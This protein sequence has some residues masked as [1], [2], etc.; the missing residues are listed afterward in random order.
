MLPV[1]VGEHSTE[2]ARRDVSRFSL[3]YG[4]LQPVAAIADALAIMMV[5]GCA[6]LIYH[7]LAGS[8]KKLLDVNFLSVALMTA[9]LFITLSYLT[10]GYEPKTRA[11]RRASI[12]SALKIWALT[13]AFMVLCAFLSKVSAQYSRATMI[14]H[15]AGGAV[16]IT[17]I[18]MLWPHL[19]R[20]AMENNLV[21]TT[22]VLVVRIGDDPDASKA[23]DLVR[24]RELRNSGLRPVGSQVMSLGLSDGRMEQLIAFVDERFRLGQLNEVILLAGHDALSHLDEVVERLRVVPVPVRFVLDPVTHKVLTRP[25]KKVG[26]LI[27]AEYQ[28]APLSITERFFKR[29][30][31]IAVSLTGMMLLSPLLLIAALAVKLDSPGPVFFKQARRGFGGK[32]FLI[33]KLRSMAVQED[34]AAVVQA[35]RDDARVTRVG[36]LL[37]RTSIDELPQLWNVFAG[38]MSIVGPRPHAVAHDDYYSQLIEDYAF[39][40]HAKPG[41][42]GWAQVKGLRGETPHVENMKAR[43]EK[44]IW[45]IDNWSIWLDIM[46][47]LRTGLVVLG[48]RTAY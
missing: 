22:T 12:I 46:I 44:D 31:D 42:T 47:I 1:G 43:I 48:Q 15:A 25:L 7:R 38:H 14:L 10:G 19:V 4:A 41:I 37:R 29:S 9:V 5:G 26:S 28:R 27:L 24:M 20:Q 32:P 23:A 45:Y 34:G 40:H 13:L 2:G 11:D 3:G 39:R 36:R 8:G 6:T 18:R 21:F 17:F 35:K 30:L 16:A 33:L